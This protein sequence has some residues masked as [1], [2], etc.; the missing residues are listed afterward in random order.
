MRAGGRFHT[1]KPSSAPASAERGDPGVAV[2]H[3]GEPERAQAPPPTWR[4][5]R[6]HRAGSPRS[7]A[8][9]PPA[10][11][12]PPP[13]A[14]GCRAGR[15]PRRRRWRP[16]QPAGAAVT[17][18]PRRPPAR[19]AGPARAERAGR[20]VPRPPARPGRRTRRRPRGRGR[21]VAAPSA[22]PAGRPR[23][24]VAPAAPRPA[25]TRIVDRGS[26]DQGHTSTS[27]G[28]PAW[29]SVRVRRRK[30]G[31]LVHR[32]RRVV[33]HGGDHPGGRGA[34]PRP[35]RSRAAPSSAPPMP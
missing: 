16:H 14:R 34:R 12:P 30:P 17:R 22:A 6:G 13:P 28:T 23:R 11:L 35:A 4:G 10:R 15:W 18:R 5:R 27:C 25:S 32:Q 29:T 31:P 26:D 20:A 7:A 24:R 9:R 33:A 3:D 2:E 21:A 1:R 19:A 8:P